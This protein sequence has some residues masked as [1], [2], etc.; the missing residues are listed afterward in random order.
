MA[1]VEVVRFATVARRVGQTALPAYRSQFSKRRFSQPQLLAILCLRRY[2]DWTFREAEVRLAEHRDLR[3]ALGLT[4]V[5]DYPTLDCF[6]RRLDE[7]MLE[8]ALTAPKEGSW[9]AV[10]V[11]ATGLASGAISTFFVKRAKDRGLKFRYKLSVAL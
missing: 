10:A 11:E 1:E 7:A 5:P 9:M 6:L 2:E 8:Q 3:E 4:H